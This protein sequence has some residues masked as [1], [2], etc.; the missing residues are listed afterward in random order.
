MSAGT[1]N[2]P[3]IEVLAKHLNAHLVCQLCNGYFREAH[4]ITEC[5]HTFCKCC[6][7]I[8][9]QNG[10]KTCPQCDSNLGSNPFEAAKDDRTLQALVDSIFP[11]FD[12]IEKEQEK[13]FY[14]DKGIPLKS[15]EKKESSSSSSAGGGI[16]SE[17]AGSDE[18]VAII[19]V[20]P[21]QS[22]PDNRRL[23]QL[24]RPTLKISRTV[25]MRKVQKFIHK[26]LLALDSLDMSN[27]D[28]TDIS[29]ACKGTMIDLAS[30]LADT[31]QK[32]YSSNMNDK[33]TLTYFLT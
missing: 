8:A 19:Q 5:M 4:T 21:D 1:K 24:E 7:V 16:K 18:V 15:M 3:K 9:V 29:L 27:I 12:V 33:I 28:V 23:P 10:A 30:S 11:D 14:A 26:R 32:F 25:Q 20:M 13:Q 2:E 6:F 31:L 17:T 22:V